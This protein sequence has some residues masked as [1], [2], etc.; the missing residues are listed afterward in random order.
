M[1]ARDLAD[2]RAASP[3]G[4]MRAPAGSWGDLAIAVVPVVAVFAAGAIANYPNLA[5]WYASLAKPAFNPSNWVFPT[6]WTVLY[7]LMAVAVWRVLRRPASR[8]VRRSA[9]TWYF[10]Q[11]AFNAAWS[12]LF[13]ALHNPL[14]G[15]ADIVP[16]LLLVVITIE[17]FRRID[18]VAALCLVPLAGWVAFAALLNLEIWRLNG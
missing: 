10:L 3:A 17:R 4:G 11:L 12:W 1:S 9:L 5:P 2:N 13:F 14:L 8:S 18:G 6:V 7:A 15:L 16:Q